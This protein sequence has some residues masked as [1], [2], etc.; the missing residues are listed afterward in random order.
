MEFLD[1]TPSHYELALD[2]MED[3]QRFSLMFLV[4]ELSS[5]PAL[6]RQ[7]VRRFIDVNHDGVITQQELM[8]DREQ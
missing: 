1:A 8:M 5:N 3:G 6:L 4:D 2:D 7:F